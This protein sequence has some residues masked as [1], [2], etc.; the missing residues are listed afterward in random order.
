MQAL[1]KCH[2]LSI[3]WHLSIALQCRCVGCCGDHAGHSGSSLGNTAVVQSNVCKCSLGCLWSVVSVRCS[4]SSFLTMSAPA[5]SAV[6]SAATA[7]LSPT[8]T[9]QVLAYL[10]FFQA[11]KEE[12]AKEI[13]AVFEEQK[14]MRSDTHHSTTRWDLDGVTLSGHC[15]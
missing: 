1:L 9:N 6:A 8:H 2:W 11:K 7:H 12:N 13:D 3:P 15:Y 5:A 10:R 14:D 4:A